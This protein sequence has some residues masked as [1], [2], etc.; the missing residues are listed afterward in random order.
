MVEAAAVALID[1]GGI[2]EAVAEDYFT[3]G[4]RGANDF[5]DE[6]GPAGGHEKEFGLAGHA[7]SGGMVFEEVADFLAKRSAAGLAQGDDRMAYFFQ[8]SSETRDLGGF[9]GTLSAFECDE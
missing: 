4:K 7:E 9:T 3:G 2:V 8:P 5:A 1:D 6:L